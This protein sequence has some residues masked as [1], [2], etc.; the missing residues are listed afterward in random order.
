MEM[1]MSGKGIY[2]F[3]NGNIY[4]GEFKDNKFCG[5]GVLT[6][7]DYILKGDFY[8]NKANGMC[9]IEYFSGDKYQGNMKNN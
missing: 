3:K 1:K 7:K 9:I 2:K 5:S 8:D 6:T 4:E